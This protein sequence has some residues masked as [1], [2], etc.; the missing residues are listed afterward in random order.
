MKKLILL[1]FA[2]FLSTSLFY[3]DA[4]GKSDRNRKVIKTIVINKNAH[5]NCSIM[6]IM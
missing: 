5:V 2:V 6:Y 1:V 4:Y 3:Y